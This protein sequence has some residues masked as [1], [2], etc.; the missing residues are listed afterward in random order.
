MSSPRDPVVQELV[1]A[2]VEVMAQMGQHFAER[3]AEVGLSPSQA[4]AL[5]KLEGA[6]SMGELAE[7]LCCD[8]SNVT[9]IV[10]RLEDRHLVERQPAPG[11]RR[12]RRLVLTDD[13]RRLR[14]A[15]IERLFADSPLSASLSQDEQRALLDL[16][17]RIAAR[18]PARS[19]S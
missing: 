5:L 16:L 19:A 7:R 3:A 11:D 13:G 6:M 17:R 15:H 2:F 18:T 10:D 4:M 9:G 8:A 1:G 12:V 14:Q